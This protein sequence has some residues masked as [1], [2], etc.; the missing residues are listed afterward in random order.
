MR[1]KNLILLLALIFQTSCITQYIWGDKSYT[2]EIEQFFVGSDGRSIALI[3]SKYHYVFSDNSGL[4]KN[5]LSL[6]NSL[7]KA[8][9]PTRRRPLISAREALLSVDKLSRIC[10]SFSLPINFLAFFTYGKPVKCR[11]AA[12]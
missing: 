7:T 9:L 2:E 5:F 4:L 3:G 12:R 1:I 11:F 6:A 8:L 10:R